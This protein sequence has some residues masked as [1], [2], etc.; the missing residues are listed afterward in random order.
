MHNMCN[1]MQTDICAC[2]MATQSEIH[3]S[4]LELHIVIV[5]L[6]WSNF[7]EL[8]VQ[9]LTYLSDSGPRCQPLDM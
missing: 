2:E 5:A 6:C 7:G 3:L 1:K 4:L 9:N 8:T